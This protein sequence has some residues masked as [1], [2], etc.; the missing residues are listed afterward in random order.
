LKD[1]TNERELE[2]A[3]HLVA[4]R[5][6]SAAGQAL[7]AALLAGAGKIKAKLKQYEIKVKFDKSTA[8]SN[9]ANVDIKIKKRKVD[10]PNTAPRLSE[11][12]S[13]RGAKFQKW[14]NELTADEFEKIWS[15]PALRK[16]IEQRLRRP[17]GVHE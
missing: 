13:V 15:D 5:L 6:T 7:L 1:A 16:Q 9:F 12:P 2:E 3:A 4:Q 14:F 11:V 8:G 17:G 10:G